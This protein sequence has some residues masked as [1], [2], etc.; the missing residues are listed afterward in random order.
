VPEHRAPATFEQVDSDR[1]RTAVLGRRRLDPLLAQ[2]RQSLDRWGHRWLV[3]PV[4]VEFGEFGGAAPTA[5]CPPRA[6]VS[7]VLLPFI[8]SFM[9]MCVYL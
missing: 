3:S 9:C 1:P 8:A 5:P 6:G 4:L 2:Q 7:H